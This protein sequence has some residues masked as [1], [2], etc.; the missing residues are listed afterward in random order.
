MLKRKLERVAIEEQQKK[1]E[2]KSKKPSA[3]C[4]PTPEDL[5]MIRR[6]PNCR[7]SRL[8]KEIAEMIFRWGV[9]L[10]CYAAGEFRRIDHDNREDP[11][12]FELCELCMRRQALYAE[13]SSAFSKDGT[14]HCSL[15]YNS[16]LV[17]RAP[18]DEEREK[19]MINT[20]VNWKKI[21]GPN[22]TRN[23]NCWEC[24]VLVSANWQIDKKPRSMV[25]YN[26]D[27][28]FCNKCAEKWKPKRDFC[29]VCI[30]QI[31][32]HELVS[33]G[34]RRARICHGCLERTLHHFSP[35]KQ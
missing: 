34:Y 33:F 15:C 23:I 26:K 3:P 19:R 10:F 30:K 1:R 6:D 32:P 7:F 24:D 20:A 18:F 28:L 13:S 22:V 11:S 27:R 8:P 4:T 16:R 5:E 25:K 2:N 12:R 29:N 31:N 35:L 17:R 9:E 21:R 14:L